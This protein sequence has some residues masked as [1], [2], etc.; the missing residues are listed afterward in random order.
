M[1]WTVIPVAKPG[2]LTTFRGCLCSTNTINFHG[3]FYC[4]VCLVEVVVSLAVVQD[5]NLALLFLPSD[6]VVVK[7]ALLLIGVEV[8]IKEWFDFFEKH[9]ERVHIEL[10]RRPVH[11]LV[12][13]VVFVFLGWIVSHV[14]RF[15]LYPK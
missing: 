10:S 2:V 8:Q 13:T 15:S 14:H 1:R 4:L 7:S 11:A 5:V 12:I 9:G 3:L 6:L